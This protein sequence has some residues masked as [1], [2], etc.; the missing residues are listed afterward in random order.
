VIRN[1]AIFTGGDLSDNLVNI[2]HKYGAGVVL[3]EKVGAE[4]FGDL[5]L[6]DI[7]VYYIPKPGTVQEAYDAY[8]ANRLTQATA[9]NNN[10]SAEK[11]CFHWFG[12]W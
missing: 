4:M 2:L 12:P 11:N 9:H 3:A 10:N 6:A 5:I 7:A 8:Q 1:E